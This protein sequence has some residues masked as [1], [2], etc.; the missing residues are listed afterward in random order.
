MSAIKIKVNKQLDGYTFSITPSI[1]QLIKELIPNAHPAKNIF[2]DYD[3][4]GD[5]DIYWKYRE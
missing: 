5:F 1:R 3:T 2:I 4:K